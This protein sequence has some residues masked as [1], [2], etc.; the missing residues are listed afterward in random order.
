MDTFYTDIDDLSEKEKLIL[1]AACKIFSAKGFSAATTNE[2]AKEAGV[3][4]GT[5]FRYFKTKKD[6]LRGLFIQIANII[7]DKMVLPSLE[8]ILTDTSRKNTREIIREIIADRI[9]AVDVYFPMMKVVISE[10]LFHED[11][12]ALFVD[13][14]VNRLIPVFDEFYLRKVAEGELRPVK[15][16]SAMRAFVGNIMIFII[17]KNVFADKLPIDDLDEEIE[18]LIDVLLFGISNHTKY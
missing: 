5:I 1:E 10:I 8:K 17:Q 9:K 2:I 15:T 18:S 14:I 11:I 16:N 6:I 4:E 13:K 12:R 7:V 3:A